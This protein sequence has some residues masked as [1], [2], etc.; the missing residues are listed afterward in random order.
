MRFL[1][2][3]FCCL[4]GCT[5]LPADGTPYFQAT[6][7]GDNLYPATQV[8]IYANDQRVETHTPHPHNDDKGFQS[9]QSVPG[10]FA[11]GLAAL[12]SLPAPTAAPGQ[13]NN[14]GILYAPDAC[15]HV[16]VQRDY[17]Y[18]D[19]STVIGISEAVWRRAAGIPP[20]VDEV[21]TSN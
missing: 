18:F 19:G 2:F 14:D 20:F 16:F 12:N 17:S 9:V 21:I 5:N 4:A 13:T 10:S 7:S 15:C 1:A 11:E 6:A 3:A 8:R